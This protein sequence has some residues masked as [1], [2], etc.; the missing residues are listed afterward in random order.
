MDREAFCSEHAWTSIGVTVI[1]GTVT[2]IWTCERC[3]AWTSE[4]LDRSTFV[5][6][7]ETTLAE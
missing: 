3:A 4:P 6:W 7:G 2:R 1:E 5:E